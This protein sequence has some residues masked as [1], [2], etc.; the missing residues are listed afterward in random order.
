MPSVDMIG[1]VI[2][3]LGKK[4]NKRSLRG[5]AVYKS[6]QFGP[7]TRLVLRRIINF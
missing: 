4:S 5:I 6:Y 1:G 3:P 2:R 7:M